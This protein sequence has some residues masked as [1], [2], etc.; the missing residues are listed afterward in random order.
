MAALVERYG[1][2]ALI[3]GGS[4]GVGASLA[5]QLAAQGFNLVLLARKPGPLEDLATEIRAMGREVRTLSLDLARP[6]AV[7]EARKLTDDIAVG[8]LVFMAGAGHRIAPFHDYPLAEWATTLNCNVTGQASFAHHYGALMRQRGKGGIV[9][10]SSMA[11]LAGS[12]SMAIYTA[13]KAFSITF[14]EALWYELKP[15]GVDA[16]ALVLGA[17]RTPAMVRTGLNLDHPDFPA[18]DPDDVA[19]EC[20]AHLGDGPVWFASG[21]GPSAQHIRAMPIRDAVVQ[22]SQST[23]SMAGPD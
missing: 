22:M 23:A 6:D 21:T 9:L 18:A 5:R 13:A 2:W 17:T 4:E 15:A 1:P 16:L 8:L 12:G 7:N 19:A 10:V 14:A 3:A 11:G 20:L